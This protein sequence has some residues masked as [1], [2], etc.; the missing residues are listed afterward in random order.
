MK[1]AYEYNNR[2]TTKKSQHLHVHICLCKKKKMHENRHRV[3]DNNSFCGRGDRMKGSLLI[4]LWAPPDPPG[5]ALQ[6]A[7]VLVFGRL[8]ASDVFVHML[9]LG[10]IQILSSTPLY[11]RT[12]WNSEKY[13]AQSLRGNILESTPK[14]ITCKVTSETPH[15]PCLPMSS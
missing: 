8:E 13:F 14:S 15:P 10:P 2:Y 5:R 11:K 3:S 6:S 9:P 4:L 7:Y 12:N 1:S